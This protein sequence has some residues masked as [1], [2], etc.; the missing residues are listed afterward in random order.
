MPARQLWI[1]WAALLAPIAFYAAL[2]LLPGFA[3]ATPQSPPSA[4][5]VA[6]LWGV[7]FLNGAL[8]LGLRAFLLVGPARRGELD[9]ASESGARRVGTLS[10]V[11]FALSE[12]V[13]VVGFVL[14]VMQ[15]DSSAL[16]ALLGASAALFAVHA[17][18]ASALR[19]EPTTE[20]RA[21]GAGRIG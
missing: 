8:S 1:L 2:P 3:A 10:I 9:P 5:L 11:H 14:Y 12:S 7:A 21:R 18:R 16:Y 4:A 15:R 20:E 19:R 17:P 13:G 6:G